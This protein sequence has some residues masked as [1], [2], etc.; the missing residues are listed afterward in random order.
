MLQTD[1]SILVLL[2]QLGTFAHH[3]RA[4]NTEQCCVFTGN[5]YTKAAMQEQGSAGSLHARTAQLVLQTHIY[6]N[7][8][9]SD[10]SVR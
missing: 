2:I 3:S 4:T 1:V 7:V 9:P 8:L 10:H 6:I 5:C